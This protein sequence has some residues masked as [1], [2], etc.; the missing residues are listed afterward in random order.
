[1]RRPRVLIADDHEPV[2]YILR[3]VVETEFDVAGE[4]TN[5]RE[6]V[7]AAV[8]VRPDVVLLDV[9]MPVM[10]GFEAARHL[11]A[12]LPEVPIIFI[13]DHAD[14]AYVDEAFRI[15]AQGYVLKR[16]SA[17]ELCPAI[18]SVLDGQ[19]FRSSA[20]SK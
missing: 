15:G 13:S 18:R 20:L 2:R 9:S 7:D 12:T 6:A 10:G 16:T 3:Q 5:G 19:S 1:V 4:A 8:H 14:T 11:R 17:N